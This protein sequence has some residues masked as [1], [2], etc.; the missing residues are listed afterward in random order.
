LLERDRT[1]V[2]HACQV[3]EERRDDPRFD[4]VIELLERVTKVLTHPCS[5]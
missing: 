2:A 1:T 3:V 4:R 5:A